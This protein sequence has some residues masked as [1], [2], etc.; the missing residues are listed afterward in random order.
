MKKLSAIIAILAA[1]VILISC[2][3]TEPASVKL[4]F[5]ENQQHDIS[6]IFNDESVDGCRVSVYRGS[7]RSSNLLFKSTFV[8]AVDDIYVAVEP[9]PARVFVLDL[10]NSSGRIIYRGKSD[11]V[12]IIAGSCDVK[13]NMNQDVRTV[14]VSI[15]KYKTE[16]FPPLPSSV[17]G[18]F[19]LS[20]F[21]V[22]TLLSG[23]D[24]K[25]L[26]FTCGEE[27][28]DLED[29][30]VKE[31]QLSDLGSAVPLDIFE[32]EGY[33]YFVAWAKNS[34]W[35]L[36]DKFSWN[37]KYMGAA[38]LSPRPADYNELSEEQKNEIDKISIEMRDCYGEWNEE[39]NGVIESLEGYNKVCRCKGLV[40]EEAPAEL[41]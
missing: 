16:V 22:D 5:P 14:N 7:V 26:N 19:N 2:E 10:L 30:L 28:C 4:A 21:V 20:V 29:A 25:K 9:G 12:D 40:E 18:N 1:A 33:V 34:E 39:V 23:N 38:L 31:I 24:V 13:I 11:P 36:T 35:Q 6:D 17:Q 37:I 41:N 8:A 32:E 3:S 15:V 27:G